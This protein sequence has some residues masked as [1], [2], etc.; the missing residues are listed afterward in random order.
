M[1]CVVQ[2][3]EVSTTVPVGKAEFLLSTTLKDKA[4]YD[5]CHLFPIIRV[6]DDV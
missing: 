3:D 1:E 2:P 6:K 5:I 4:H